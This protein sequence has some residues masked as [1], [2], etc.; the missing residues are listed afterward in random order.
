MPLKDILVHVDASPHAAVRL[1]LAIILARQHA[2]HLIGLHVVDTVL[3][4]MA[5]ADGSGGGAL[6]GELIDQLRAD[7]LA[8]ATG[9][10]ARFRE[11]L[12]REAL[13]GEWRLA[14]GAT[15]DA[16]AFHARTVDLAVVGQRDPEADSSSAGLVVEQVLFAAGR[17]VLVVPYAGHFETL[18]RRV[19]VGW[20]E[21]PE[22]AR[23]VAD[24][25]PLLV[26][27][28][29]VLVLTVNPDDVDGAEPGAAIALHLAR[30]GVR[31]QVEHVTAPDTPDA[32][33]LLNKASELGADLLVI[34]AYGHSRL[35]ELV[36]G[37][38][39]RTLLQSMTVPVLLSH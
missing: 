21:S 4:T 28:E 13:D 11:T 1:Q 36:L 23:A 29:R 17:P 35:R 14:E 39:T 26:A 25:M 22:A 3:P 38:V 5:L 27:A 34:G 6:L 2:A 19:L 30:H 20:N 37:G 31:A 12:R 9:I 15:P 16:V 33:V 18:G 32:A 7:G 24:A 10:E 8:A